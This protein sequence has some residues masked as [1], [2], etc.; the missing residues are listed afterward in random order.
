MQVKLGQPGWRERYYGEKFGARTP[1][2]IEEIRRDV[3]IA[4]AFRSSL[5]FLLLFSLV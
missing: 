1:A 2:Q 3:V 5:D 4:S